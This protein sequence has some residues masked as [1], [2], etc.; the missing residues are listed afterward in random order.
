MV[1]DVINNRSSLLKSHQHEYVKSYTEFD[2][3]GRLDK[4]HQTTST[5]KNGDPTVVT[6]YAYV[7]T[8][9]QVVYMKEYEGTWVS[10]WELF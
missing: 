1:G 7:G 8:T 9:S 5:A 6:Q 3:Y 2:A 4:L 10:I